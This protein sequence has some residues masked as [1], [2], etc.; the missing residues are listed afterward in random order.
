[1]QT[2]RTTEQQ[3]DCMEDLANN[4]AMTPT[5]VRPPKVGVMRFISGLAIAP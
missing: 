3:N 2:D 4:H 5:G 1:M